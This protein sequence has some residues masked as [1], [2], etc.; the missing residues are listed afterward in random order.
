MPNV[1]SIE[2]LVNIMDDHHPDA[3]Q[4][5]GLFEQIIGESGGSGGPAGPMQS[6]KHI[7]I[8]IDCAALIQVNDAAKVAVDAASFSPSR[9]LSSFS[10]LEF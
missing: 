7:S 5:A 8:E 2:R 10:W 3:L 6:S 9:F 1:P 4:A